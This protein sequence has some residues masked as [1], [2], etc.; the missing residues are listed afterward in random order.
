M[1]REKTLILY[2]EVNHVGARVLGQ[3]LRSFKLNLIADRLYYFSAIL[4]FATI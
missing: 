1:Q 3:D 4:F 2:S